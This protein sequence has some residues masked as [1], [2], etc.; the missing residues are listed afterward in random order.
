MAVQ[1][2]LIAPTAHP[3]LEEALRQKL[4]RRGEMVGSLGELEPLAIRLGLIQNT[5]RP[6]LQ[7]PQLMVFAGDHGL[8]VDGLSV[9]G[10]STLDQVAHLLA[11]RLPMAVFSFLQGM[12][13]TVVDAGLAEELRPDPA[14][15]P[16]KIGFGTR[17]ARVAAAMTVDQAH[18]AIRAGME[19]ADTLP[20]NVLACAG[21]GVG[22]HESA[23][24]VISKLAEVPLEALATN[25][26]RSAPESLMTVLQAARVRHADV[27]DPVE[28]LAAFG[29]FEIAMMVGALLVSASKRHLI[30]VDGMP[31]CAALLVASR[32]AAPVT[33]YVVFCRSNAH[34]GL[35]H[36]LALFG[37]G[38]LLELGMESTDGTGAALS[39]PMVNCAAA[40]LSDV[41][42][43]DEP[44]SSQYPPDSSSGPSSAAGHTG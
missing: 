7:R 14:L 19:I 12:T 38:A 32:I 41:A 10:Q 16:R 44:A 17:N 15:L 22:S 31:A 28:V 18:A 1:R 20:G 33:D 5:L 35:D 39:W 13:I 30:M 34:R 23:S 29:G 9:R 43:A 3:R 21:I 25:G 4:Q 2:S 37:A 40:L 11:G 27:A 26:N 8:V 42:D 24:L 6:R 36:A